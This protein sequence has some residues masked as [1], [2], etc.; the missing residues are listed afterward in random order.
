MTA[1]IRAIYDGESFVPEKRYQ[2]LCDKEFAAGETYVIEVGHERSKVSHDQQFA[3]LDDAWRNLPEKYQFEPWAQSP[4]HL[5]KYALIRTGCCTTEQFPCSTHAE[6]MR[7]ATRLR[8][9]D[10]YCL[11]HVD[12]AVV[13]RFRAKSQ[14]RR[15]M[16]AKEFQA[17]KQAALDFVAAL[18]EVDSKTLQREAGKAA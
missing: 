5:R 6:A 15:A 9:D 8:S 1:P 7:W 14:K 16:N 2:R 18:L 10:E 11:V 3:W 4:E 13:N 17:S 12:G